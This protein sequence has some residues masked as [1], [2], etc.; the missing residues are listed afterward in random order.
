[1]SFCVMKSICKKYFF[2]FFVLLQQMG[3]GCHAVPEMAS[4][5]EGQQKFASGLLYAN[6][7]ELQKDTVNGLTYIHIKSPWKGAQVSY[8]YVLYSNEEQLPKELPKE[9]KPIRV[10]VR[11]I[12]C[13]ST[14]HAAFIDALGGNEYIV[15]IQGAKYL[16][17]PALLEKV[18][19]G[20]IEEL[21]SESSINL[22]KAASVSPDVV[23]CYGLDGSQ[24]IQQLE[25]LQLNPIVIAEYMEEHPLGRA[26]WIKVFG[27]LMGRDEQA[28]SIFNGIVQRYEGLR[29]RAQSARTRPKVMTGIALQGNWYVP[30]GNSYVAHHIR[31]AGGTYIWQHVAG[32]FSSML[33]M[34]TAFEGALTADYWINVG[35]VNTLEDILGYDARYAR[36]PAFKE[37]R[38]YNSNRK[39]SVAGGHDIYESGVVCPDV[40]LHDLISILHPDMVEQPAYQPIYYHPIQ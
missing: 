24:H 12:A 16:V 7:L 1:M 2:W 25:K 28:D 11:K 4:E 9:V 27:A 38:V 40:V 6:T 26:E 31:D 3:M 15:G 14:T 30:E 35:M 20:A 22:E 34:E 39:V 32:S 17:N 36:L 37:R 10:P 18:R 8:R 23:T 29:L 13:T 19:T 33:D 5:Q 21:G